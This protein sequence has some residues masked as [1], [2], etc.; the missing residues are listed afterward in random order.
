MT[1]EEFTSI[2]KECGFDCVEGGDKFIFIVLNCNRS[3]WFSYYGLKQNEI[4]ISRNVGIDMDENRISPSGG[5]DSYSV[6]NLDKEYYRNR[7][8]NLQK[9]IKKLKIKLKRNELEKDFI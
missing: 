7:M 9:E 1:A 3:Y 2:S 5:I 6:V 8:L 4:K